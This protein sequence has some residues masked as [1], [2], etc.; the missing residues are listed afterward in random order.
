MSGNDGLT[1]FAAMKFA[2]TSF[3]HTSSNHFIVTRSPNH[4]CAVSCAIRF[5][6]RSC[7]FCVAVL[8]S[9]RARRVVE[10]GAGVLHAAELKRRQQHEVELL[11]RILAIG[12]GFEPVDRLL[13]EVEDRLAIGRDFR[14][15]GFAVVHVKRAAVAFAALD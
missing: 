2:N 13:M 9:N 15:V 4:M 8:S 3:S 1:I 11:E 6:R 14:G 12:V 10:N 7:S 5:A